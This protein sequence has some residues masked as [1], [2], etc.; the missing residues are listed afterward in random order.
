MNKVKKR[1][2]SLFIASAMAMSMLGSILS[3][4]TSSISESENNN[5]FSTANPITTNNIV[6]GKLSTTSDVDYFKFT[7][8]E[9]GYVNIMLSVPSNANYNFKLYS[10]SNNLLATSSSSSTGVGERLTYLCS[11]GQTYRIQVYAGGTTV[12]TSN[13]NLYVTPLMK[14][15]K[16]WYSQVSGLYNYTT[17]DA[18]NTN[19][20]DSLYFGC[21]SYAEP[22]ILNN[23]NDD[24]MI[25]ACPVTCAAMVLRNLNAVTSSNI[26]DF[27]TG[28]YGKSYADPFIVAMANIGVTTAPTAMSNGTYRYTSTRKPYYMYEDSWDNVASYFNKTVD[29]EHEATWSNL[30]SMLSEKISSTSNVFKYK[31]G[32]IV[33][34]KHTSK[35][36]HYV[37]FTP[38]SSGYEIYDPGTQGSNAGEG[39]TS[40]TNAYFYTTWGFTTS[41]I[42]EIITIT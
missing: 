2:T 33:H 19:K 15:N 24:L 5:T 40:W 22:F 1:V 20:L 38:T 27:R 17:N 13:Y 35:G 26:T 37:V 18:W 8:T 25:K 6:S 30:Q 32:I 23:S 12:S 16:A 3:Y 9:G 36:E 29:T 14:M 28:Y 11:A 39:V 10:S 41:D 42:K 4:A 21:D 34:F 7:T 31:Q